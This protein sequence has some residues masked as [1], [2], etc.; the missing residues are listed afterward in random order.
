MTSASHPTPAGTP[1]TPLTQSPAFA[2]GLAA[3]A[4]ALNMWAFMN[5]GAFAT[6]QTGNLIASVLYLLV[7]QWTRSLFVLG[8]LLAFGVGSAVS[9]VTLQLAS[10]RGKHASPALL[11]AE[12]VLI[13]ASG[14]LWAL[15]VVP[16]TLTVAHILAM[17]IAF[18][19]GAQTN[20]FH[21]ISGYS[22]GTVSITAELRSLFH[23]LA[24]LLMR[25][26]TVRPQESTRVWTVRFTAV[27]LGFA[28]GALVVAGFALVA[29]WPKSSLSGS[30][31]A[32]TGWALLFPAA[33]TVLLAWKVSRRNSATLAKAKQ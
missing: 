10:R 26:P 1:P 11:I 29:G 17:V 9:T 4:G 21:Q 18:I 28:A 7:G 33:I 25:V 31:M 19:A 32:R 23:N 6:S 16:T 20:A 12:A 15:K 14:L 8:S 24:L 30:P 2:T 27:L 13:S 5:A 22:F 3:V